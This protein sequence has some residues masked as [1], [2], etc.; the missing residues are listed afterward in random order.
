M[1]QQLWQ[2][3]LSL[4]YPPKCIH[5]FDSVKNPAD[6]FCEVCIQQLELID[7]SERCPYCFSSETPNC[8]HCRK[9]QSLFTQSASAFDYMGPPAT[10]VQRMKYSGQSYLAE[11]LG[12]YLT[13][14]FI[15]L[16]WPLPD[17]II[18]V[19]ISW[20]HRLIR[21]YNQ[22]D[23]LAETVGI[24]LQRPV[25]RKL[26]RRAGDFSQAGLTQEQ[27][28][29]LEGDS[30][31]LKGKEEFRDKTLL[32]IDDVMTTGRTLNLCAELLSEEGPKEIY[33]LTVCRTI[34]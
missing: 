7:P 16:G 27:R 34:Q 5:C 6:R 9:Q 12:G 31:Y 29:Q 23:L 10:L 13:T 30:F 2:A 25:S 24:I 11:G 17:V 19:P 1:F 33:G 26:K 21:G 14:Q 3:T 4:V 15:R 20:T 32:L 18:P 22:C 8:Y 28:L